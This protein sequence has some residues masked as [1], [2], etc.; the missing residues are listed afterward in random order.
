MSM[1]LVS[2]NSQRSPLAHGATGDEGNLEDLFQRSRIA[3]AINV[4][5]GATLGYSG[6]AVLSRIEE[7]Y[8]MLP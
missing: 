2:W 1:A 4:L 3:G 5:I 6:F 8:L 7:Q